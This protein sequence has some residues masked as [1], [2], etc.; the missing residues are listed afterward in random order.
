MLCFSVFSLSFFFFLLVVFC[1]F[2]FFFQAE[3]GIRDTS[4][5]GVQT[6][7]LPISGVRGGVATAR[8]GA[9]A[10][11]RQRLENKARHDRHARDDAG[12]AQ[13]QGR[14]PGREEEIGR[15]SCREECRSRWSAE[16]YKKNREGVVNN[17]ER[18]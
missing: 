3:D 13:G 4:V 9:R 15:A 8:P 1:F 6:C 18:E 12:A 10:A 17:D 2:F 14:P 7:A 16:H 11:R 5:T